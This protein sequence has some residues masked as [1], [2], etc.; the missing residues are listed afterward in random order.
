MNVSIVH[1]GVRVSP[2]VVV[3][4]FAIAD[5][6]PIVADLDRSA[7]EHLLGSRS[8]D[9]NALMEALHSHRNIVR[10]GIEAYV[11]ARGA[12]LDGRMTL[13]ERDL[14]PFAEQPAAAG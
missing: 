9:R 1:T 12:P 2:D 14:R 7:I 4:I 3:E 8:I 6:K 10:R 13:S 11:L 5:G